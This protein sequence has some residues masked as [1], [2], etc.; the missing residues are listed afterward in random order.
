VNDKIRASSVRLIDKDGK[1]LG[2]VSLNEALEIANNNN[3]DLVN[4]QPNTN[5]PVC[6]ILDYGKLK[7]EERLK[8]KENKK[9][10]KVIT[11]QI[12]I[13][14]NINDHDLQTKI[15]HALEFIEKNIKVQFVF[16]LKG[17]EVL[18]KDVTISLVNKIKSLLGSVKIEKEP[19]IGN[20]VMVMI[21]S[22][23]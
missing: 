7:Y 5:P 9:K 6:K 19:E 21:V 18:N 8:E 11:K 13:K 17:R 1:Q 14:Q 12:E 22:G 3:L 10:N 20:K 4:I 2:I 23:G 16:K 15:R